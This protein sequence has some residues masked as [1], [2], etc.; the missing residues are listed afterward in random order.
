MS[1]QPHTAH[2]PG[3]TAD[4]RIY[5]LGPPEVTWAGRPLSIPRRQARALLYRLA[6]HLQPVPR[7][8]LCF[9]FWPD[10]PESTARL[11]LSRLLHHLRRALPAPD[12]IL[13]LEDRMKNAA[14]GAHASI[15][16]N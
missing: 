8:Q 7:E 12:V 5:L 1:C 13:T 2:P 4:L 15:A 10:T 16:G 9:L 6:V 11:N 14:S 3:A